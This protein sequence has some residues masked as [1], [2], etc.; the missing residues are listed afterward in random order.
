MS[1][2][3]ILF[4]LQSS[5]L[6]SPSPPPPPHLF[7]LLLNSSRCEILLPDV[8]SSP[9]VSSSCPHSLPSLSFSLSRPP[10]R[11]L[12]L[13]FLYSN[14]LITLPPAF[15]PLFSQIKAEDFN[16]ITPSP[17]PIAL[18]SPCLSILSRTGESARVCPLQ[19]EPEWATVS[20]KDPHHKVDP[21]RVPKQVSQWES[22]VEAV[23]STL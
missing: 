12:F 14:S 11:S 10:L 17:H 2:V 21:F 20:R 15:A 1:I 9:L 4:S 6:P 5:L 8:L 22:E 19:M 16:L 3:S 13:T 18:L 7:L 23:S